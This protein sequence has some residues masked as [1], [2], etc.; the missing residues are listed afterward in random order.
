VCDNCMNRCACNCECTDCSYYN[1]NCQ[2]K[3]NRRA[4]IGTVTE[5]KSQACNCD[6]YHGQCSGFC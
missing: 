4:I 3:D 1:C 6:C 5:C 2:V